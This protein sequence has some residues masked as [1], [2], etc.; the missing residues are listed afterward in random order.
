MKNGIYKSGAFEIP[1]WESIFGSA[2]VLL[3]TG[4]ITYGFVMPDGGGV[5][6]I[7]VLSLVLL[8]SAFKRY[9]FAIHLA[10]FFLLLFILPR[11][12]AFLNQWPL[13]ILV[14]LLVY[15]LIVIMVPGLRESIGWLKKGRADA[16]VMK[17]V[18]A[19]SILSAI[20]LFGWVILITPDIAHQVAL[21]PDM[22]LWL[23]PIAGLG[24]AIFNATM[25]E[26]VFRGIVMDA[27]DSGLGDNYI[28][29]CLQAV[30]FAAFHYLVGFPKGL[31]GFFMVL[32]YGF[33]LGAIK[34]LSKGMLA[35]L[36]AHVAADIT[37]FS[38]LTIIFFR[39]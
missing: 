13:R 9:V 33:M 18:L 2:L 39:G 36:M 17:W 10:L 38:I 14:P 20:A 30:P 28:S 37:I 19:T 21:I 8:V 29:V 3:A 26:A 34:R 27:T 7:V 4:V 15:G 23:Y 32:V 5:I 12:G 6:A 22:P 16:K 25:E 24:F 11:L 35:P 31:I 1:P